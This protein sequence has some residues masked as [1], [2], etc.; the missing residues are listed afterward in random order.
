MWS[1]L[2]VAARFG[3]VVFMMTTEQVINSPPF[4][5]LVCLKVTIKRYLYVLCVGIRF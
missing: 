2:S 3:Y 1:G 5:I 4:Y